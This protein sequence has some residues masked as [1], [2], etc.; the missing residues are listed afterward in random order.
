MQDFYFFLSVWL[1]NS[2]KKT[3]ERSL[4]NANASVWKKKEPKI[5]EMCSWVY[6]Y[7]CLFVDW[8]VR[9]CGDV[10][11]AKN[12]LKTSG[13]S[14]WGCVKTSKSVKLTLKRPFDRCPTGLSHTFRWPPL[15]IISMA[16]HR[17]GDEFRLFMIFRIYAMISSSSKNC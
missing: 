13:Q 7:Q 12:P 8:F 2:E 17:N 4:I 6:K 5:A 16:S 14:L 1:K 11:K 9:L 10:W 3:R 15:S